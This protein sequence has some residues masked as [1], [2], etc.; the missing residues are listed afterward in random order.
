MRNQTC[1][2]GT[3]C[4]CGEYGTGTGTKEVAL[5][6]VLVA[7]VTGASKIVQTARLVFVELDNSGSHCKIRQ[8]SPTSAR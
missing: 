1:E 2:T 5:H 3:G 4:G 7:K 6:S 8:A